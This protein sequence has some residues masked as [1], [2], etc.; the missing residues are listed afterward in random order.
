MPEIGMWIPAAAGINRIT[1]FRVMGMATPIA[2][3]ASAPAP[4]INSASVKN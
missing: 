4:L 1:M 3:P 2:I